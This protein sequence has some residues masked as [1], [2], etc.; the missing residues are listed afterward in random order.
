MMDPILQKDYFRGSSSLERGNG[1]E[2]GKK[3]KDRRKE[4]RKLDKLQITAPGRTITH[5]HQL[6][7]ICRKQ[8]TKMANS[9]EKNSTGQGGKTKKERILL[10]AP[11]LA[12]IC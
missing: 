2:E 9:D 1:R 4:Q 8:Q 12:E 10:S 3:K 7:P 5:R 11:D 6:V